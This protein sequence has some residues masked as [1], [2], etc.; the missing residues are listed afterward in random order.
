M[1]PIDYFWRGV[2]RIIAPFQRSHETTMILKVSDKDAMTD[3]W[4]SVVN[5]IRWAIDEYEQ[6]RQRNTPPD[7]WYK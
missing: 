7:E 1:R 3:D 2:S 4:R 6:E 5:D